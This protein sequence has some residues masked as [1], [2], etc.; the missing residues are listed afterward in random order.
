MC[1]FLSMVNIGCQCQFFYPIYILV[2]SIFV[3][4]GIKERKNSAIKFVDVDIFSYFEDI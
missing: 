1:M 3:S 2:L 4:G